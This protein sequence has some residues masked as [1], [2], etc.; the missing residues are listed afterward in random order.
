VPG[1]CFATHPVYAAATEN[2]AIAAITGKMTSNGRG[3]V[4]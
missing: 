1:F 3:K 2:E 4:S